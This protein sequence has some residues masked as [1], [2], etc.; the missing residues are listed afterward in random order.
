MALLVLFSSQLLALLLLA[1]LLGKHLLLDLLSLLLR[2]GS[3]ALF[4]LLLLNSCLVFLDLHLSCADDGA[5]LLGVVCNVLQLR[6]ALI[7]LS[8]ELYSFVAKIN[9]LCF[10]LYLLLLLFTCLVLQAVSLLLSLMDL[11][12]I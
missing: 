2:L 7:N 1:K 8:L 5:A 3:L 6:F 12:T 9:L 11:I 4:I 10:Q